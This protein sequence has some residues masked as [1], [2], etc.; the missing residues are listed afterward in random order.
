MQM[1][2]RAL[3]RRR[4]PDELDRMLVVAPSR[5]W[6]AVA[7]L[8]MAVG[9]LLIWGFTGNLPRQVSAPGVLSSGSPAPIQSL[10]EG[11]VAEVQA[12]PGQ[13]LERG[14]AIAVVTLAGNRARTITSP[15]DGR[16]VSVEIAPGQVVKRGSP[17]V[18]LE[19]SERGSSRLDA[20]VFLDATDGASVA[21]GMKVNLQVASAP[22]ARFGVVRGRI[23]SV[24]PYPASTTALT[25]MLGNADL[26]ARFGRDGP[27][28]VAHVRLA[29]DP[30]TR[31]GLRWSTPEGAPFALQPGV[32][33]SAQ[34]IQGSQTPADV[35]FGT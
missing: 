9:G 17:L 14:Q 8:T 5:A 7:A 28:I 11:Q 3:E 30:S 29:R 33:L 32:S 12:R 26:A 16:V 27:P 21:P 24:A 23:T 35:V 20:L 6:L 34:V 22:A 2:T 31:S 4:M 13:D 1:R 19:P 18:T 25:A 15:F 10:L